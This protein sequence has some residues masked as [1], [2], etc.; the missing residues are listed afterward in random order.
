LISYEEALALTR[1]V[2][3]ARLLP[4]ES[5]PLLRAH[6]RVLVEDVHARVRVPR[7]AS[8]SMDG[9]AVRASDERKVRSVIGRITAGESASAFHVAD[10]TALEIMTGAPVPS[11]ADAVVKVEDIT[12]LEL[13]DSPFSPT[14]QVSSIVPRGA[15]IEADPVA[16]GTHIRPAGEDYA[17]NQRVLAAGSRLSPEHLLALAHTGHRDVEVRARPRVAI[18]PTGNELEE[19]GSP[20]RHESSVWASTSVYLATAL[21]SLGCA[22]TLLP[23]V[24]D[25][26]AA[27]HAALNSCT[28]AHL[29]CTTGAVSAGVHDFIPSV[30]V[31]R[32]AHTY[33]HRV[34][35][36]PAKPVLLATHDAQV[37]FGL[38][39]NPISTAVAFRFFVWPL[40]AAMWGMTDEQPQRRRLVDNVRKP[41]DLRCFFK[42]HTDA[43]HVHVL[44]GQ[45][46]HLVR[47][48]VEANA[49][50]MLD[51]E[52]NAGDEVEIFPL[53]P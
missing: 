12:R 10:A 19:A 1:E 44:A 49:W 28:D 43:T 50:V 48:L 42:A 37:L 22:V 45:A 26:V 36:R 40:L 16:S 4:S 8:S 25:D 21:E 6:G 47:P 30:F 11:G 31:E 2:G 24:R 29:I 7:F 17:Q 9:F 5:V 15:A 34:A 51:G 23:I 53:Q 32:G 38:P 39:G 35:V 3:R 20:L 52:V 27:F 33:F 18:I 46:S 14:G 13:G 41:K